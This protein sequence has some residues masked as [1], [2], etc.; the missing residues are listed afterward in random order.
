[1]RVRCVPR[2]SGSSAG[3]DRRA[4]DG[5]GM[6][7]PNSDLETNEPA[8]THRTRKI[9]AVVV[10]ITVVAVGATAAFA[11]TKSSPHTYRTAT[12]STGAVTKTLD[13]SGVLQPIAQAT[14][15]FPIAGTVKTV[16][17]K[18][19]STV[20][21]GQTIATLDTTSLQQ[22]LLS[23][24]SQLASAQLT[25]YKALHGESVTGSGS[26]GSTGGNSNNNGSNSNAN[27]NAASYSSSSTAAASIVEAAF[28]PGNGTQRN[29]NGRSNGSGNGQQTSGATSVPAA[30]LLLI[31]AQK[32]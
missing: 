32:D 1:R 25:L 6:R 10:I 9:V 30:Q 8:P 20:T 19:G 17:V 23:K 29:S 24:Q 7:R 5:V 27:V 15:A 18:A 31:A 26:H 3:T 14:V 4:T 11:L 28:T 12:V 16:N 2:V 21:A 22:Q 13:N